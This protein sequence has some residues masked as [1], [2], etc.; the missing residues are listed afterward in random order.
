MKLLTLSSSLVLSANAAEMTDFFYGASGSLASG[1]RANVLK[2]FFQGN[3]QLTAKVLQHGCHCVKLD[4][5]YQGTVGGSPVDD[6]DMLC[7]D[8][9]RDRSCISLQD[10]GCFD[11]QTADE[12]SINASGQ[13]GCTASNDCSASACG[14]DYRFI[15]GFRDAVGW[16]TD[17]G[18][19][20]QP[21]TSAVC[22]PEVDTEGKRT[23]CCVSS[24]KNTP[25]NSE[26]HECAAGVLG[27]AGPVWTD[28]HVPKGNSYSNHQDI[29]NQKSFTF[30][31]KSEKDVHMAFTTGLGETEGNMYEVVIGGW[32]NSRTV[33]R[34]KKRGTILKRKSFYDPRVLVPT[35]PD[36]GEYTQFTL[37]WGT[38][39]FIIYKE[40]EEF[41][42]FENYM[43]EP[44]YTGREFTAVAVSNQGGKSGEWKF[45]KPKFLEN[46]DN[47]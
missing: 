37:D 17:Q 7:R 41:M 10:G 14:I 29:S 22:I 32:G 45:D 26:V 18:A 27:P 47:Y 4:V 13:P 38:A 30:Q 6:L 35:N 19:S 24:A 1:N 25:Y 9:I 11:K 3:Q 28:V 16:S 31:T 33:F 20:F 23:H 2:S 15:Q 43:S 34:T 42:R 39:D 21:D 44:T 12:Y 5:D 46:L 40:G 36:H 8:W